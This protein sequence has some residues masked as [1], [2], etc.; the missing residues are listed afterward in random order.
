MAQRIVLQRCQLVLEHEF[1][2]VEQPA[3]ERR[4]AIIHR[5]A[6]QKPQEGLV[7]LRGDI[8]PYIRRWRCTDRLGSDLQ[9]QKYP[10]RFFFSIE[11]ASSWSIRRP[12]RSD[13]GAI[14]ISAT[15]SSSVSA[16]DSAAAVSG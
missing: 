15:T 16:S 4:L 5:P 8:G 10:S 12:W 9:H 6:R 13:E 1:C 7:L 11:P 3:D 14:S 2:I